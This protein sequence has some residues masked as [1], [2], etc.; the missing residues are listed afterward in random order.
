[1]VTHVLGHR[2]RGERGVARWIAEVIVWLKEDGAVNACGRD[3]FTSL[4][5]LRFVLDLED[6]DRRCLS[7]LASGLPGLQT[8][9]E[10]RMIAL[11]KLLGER[12]VRPDEHVAIMLAVDQ[13]SRSVDDSRFFE[14]DASCHFSFLD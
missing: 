4:E 12:D 13:S 5:K 14:F 8:H 11:C 2:D 3:A 1:M 7:V 10:R 9:F 6:D